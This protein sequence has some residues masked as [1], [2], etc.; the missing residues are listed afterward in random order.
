[1]TFLVLTA[2]FTALCAGVE[3]LAHRA[4]LPPELLRKLAHMSS[5]V[6]AAFL[7]LVATFPEIAALG[8]LFAVVMAASLRFRVFNAIHD[9]SRD[10]YGEVCFPLGI[11][12]LALA[13]PSPAP[14]AFGV[15]VLGL[16]DGLAALVG[17]RYGRRVVPVF[18]TRKTLW[19][20]GTFLVTT[21]VLGVAL[22]APAGV[23]LPHAIAAGAAMA[24]VLTPVE[25]LLTRGFDNLVLPA[26]AGALLAGL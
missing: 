7:P 21:F 3:V 11:A 14:F 26:L 23:P 2:V 19:G 12:A 10:T 6:L 1:V 24:I 15:L 8:F 22:L 16:G 13:F 9:V 4:P 20:S 18:E 5:A 17:G 25:L